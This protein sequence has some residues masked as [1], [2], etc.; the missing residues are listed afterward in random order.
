M[1]E[2]IIRGSLDLTHR[3]AHQEQ[4]WKLELEASRELLPAL[5]ETIYACS[6]ESLPTLSDFEI[7]EGDDIR[8]LE[9]Y[10]TEK[11]DLQALQE[12]I[13]A[14]ASHL[15]H[16]APTLKLSALENEDWVSK[17]QKILQPVDAGRFFVYGSH[18]ADKL[19]ADKIGLLVEAGQAFG[20]GQHETTNGCLLALSDL[21][22]ET[23]PATALDLGCGSGILALAMCK[24]WPI[25]IMASDIDPIATETT[26]LNARVNDVACV[27]P[28][29][30]DAGL[31][32]LTC[33]G[34]DDKR[35]Q[36]NGPYE[37][38]TANILA[39]P[40]QEMAAD[41]VAHLSEN[42]SLILSGL[43]ATQEDAVLAAYAP[44]GL[45]LKKRYCLGEWN[46]L[47]LKRE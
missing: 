32:A 29:C 6:G 19:P 21:A 39:K 25:K 31:C 24:L 7:I 38:I 28:P 46:S 10:F 15:G 45:K 36:D 41:I 34:M 22:Q 13:N 35:L 37:V 17:S 8:L 14:T 18:D 40:L 42:G 23:P 9:G 11:P 44:L 43:L 12:A 27:E 5:E 47:L 16:P 26:L 1:N 3:T 33:D 2:N 4:V 20:T 30:G